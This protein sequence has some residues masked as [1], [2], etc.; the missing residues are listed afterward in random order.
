MKKAGQ[1]AAADDNEWHFRSDIVIHNEGQIVPL[2]KED[3]SPTGYSIQLA[4][5]T[6]QN[7]RLPIL[8]LGL[9]DDAT[10]R[11]LN[12]TWTNI[13]ASR[14]GFN[15]RWI[16]AGLTLKEGNTSIGY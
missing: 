16:Q 3:G 14:A 5:L 2:T 12:Y 15:Q 4:R 7:G 1:D 13:G 11:T 8:K 9:I 10:G 6:Y